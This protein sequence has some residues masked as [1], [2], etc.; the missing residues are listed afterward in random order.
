LYRKNHKSIKVTPLDKCSIHT[1]SLLADIWRVFTVVV[2]K[3]AN[4]I[5]H[6]LNVEVVDRTRINNAD[7]WTVKRLLVDYYEYNERFLTVVEKS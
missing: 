3:Q 5:N 1:L 6:V 4:A 2:T 7:L